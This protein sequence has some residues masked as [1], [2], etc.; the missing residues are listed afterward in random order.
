MLTL[1]LSTSKRLAHIVTALPIETLE[2]I[3]HPKATLHHSPHHPVPNHQYGILAPTTD[4]D[5]IHNIP[6]FHPIPQALYQ[7]LLLTNTKRT[8]NNTI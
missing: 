5:C 1:T 6:Y 7:A 2:A 4:P 3:N 8:N